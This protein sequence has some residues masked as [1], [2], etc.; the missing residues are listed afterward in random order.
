MRRAFF[1]VLAVLPL[2]A[3]DCGGTD[4]AP[5]GPSP[6][7]LSVSGEVSEDL[8]CLV[9]A[10]L[11]SL[12]DPFFVYLTCQP[13]ADLPGAVAW[14]AIWGSPVPNQAYGWDS[15]GTPATSNVYYGSAMRTAPDGTGDW[16]HHAFAPMGGAGGAGKLQYVLT[17]VGPVLDAASGSVA[18]HGTLSATVPSRTGGAAVTF[19]A[20]F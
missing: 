12:S 18:V 5:L 7:T 4:P 20:T 16:T 14:F 11:P 6:C 15:T 1:L 10:E 3:F 9:T 13:G 17:S 2:A 19:S 8:E